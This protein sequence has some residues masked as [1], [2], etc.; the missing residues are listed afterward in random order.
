MRCLIAAAVLCVCCAIPARA[1]YLLDM[2][3]AAFRADDSLC[4]VEIYMSIQR[5]SLHYQSNDSGM[6]AEFFV[7]LAVLQDTQVVLADTFYALDELDSA[8]A[9]GTAGQFFTH[10]F[11]FFIQ[12]GGYGLRASLYQY[13]IQ[14]DDLRETLKIPAYRLDSLQVSS[15]ELGTH[16][17][18]TD[19][20]SRY[21]KNGVRMIP[22]PTRFF[23][24]KLPLFYYYA[25]VYGLDFSEALPD[26]YL[27]VRRVLDAET[28][29]SVRSDVHKLYPTRGSTA[30]IADG[31]P[32][33][34]LRTGTYVLEL[35]VS[36]LR[37]GR[38]TA[39]RKKF[40]TYRRE[41]FAAGRALQ[42]RPSFDARL[43]GAGPDALQF[44]D[45]DSVLMW[46][47]YILSTD[48]ARRVERLNAEGKRGFLSEFW[49][50]H[51]RETAE[52]ANQYL[53]KVVESNVRYSF[54][55][56]PGWKTDR[57]RIFILYG[58]P[59][60]INNN[61]GGANLPDHE[62][63]EYDRLE[64]GVVF[65]FF[66]RSG[67]GDLDLVHSTKRGEIYNPN[68]MTLA[69]ASQSRAGGLR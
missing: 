22:N 35:S 61:Y 41:D 27:V 26:S 34:A 36:S 6:T 40:W 52:T 48:E 47:R 50:R 58:E 46:M 24:I 11:R 39:A 53:A 19:E 9:S 33:S 5:S 62:V 64:G 7:Q 30:V 18:F 20:E 17:E 57:G 13:G 8:Q 32:V 16:M 25:E 12:P 59:D 60:R 67:F 63:W 49:I 2:D 31:F 44:V 66:D 69:P 23:G 4:Y 37:S 28:G 15:I 55:K 43:Q 21:V 45:A 54:L 3:A 10:I 14:R 65:V 68:W 29:Q 42:P 56:R 51:E 1:G 38:S